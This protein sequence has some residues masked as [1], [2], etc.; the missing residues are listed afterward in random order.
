MTTHEP[1]YLERALTARFAAEAGRFRG[2]V[3]RAADTD[4][5]IGARAAALADIAGWLDHVADHP[6][7]D[8]PAANFTEAVLV[9]LAERLCPEPIGDLRIH[10]MAES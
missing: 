2:L 1:T 10:W 8:S 6:E 5:S 7:T 3:D 4:A 9:G